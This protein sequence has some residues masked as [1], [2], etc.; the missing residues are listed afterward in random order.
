MKQLSTLL[1]LLVSQHILAQVAFQDSNLPIVV[2]DTKG[3]TIID[4]PKVD[5]HLGIVNNPGGLNSIDDPFNEY[6][7]KIG[8]EIRGSSSQFLFDKKSFGLET[9]DSTG[10][11]LNVGLFGFPPENDWVLHGPYS[12]KSLIRNLLAMHLARQLGHYTPRTQLC[13]L[14][15]NGDYRGVYLFMEKIKRD[16]GRV[17]I[18]KLKP[19]EITGDN[20]TGGYII[21]LDKYDGGN[22]GKGWSSPFPPNNA[23][24]GKEVFFQFDYPKVDQIVPQ[25]EE[26]IKS[27]VSD[28]EWALKG[29]GFRDPERGY[30]SFID[31]SSF[32]DF[33][34]V[35]E[36]TRNVDGYRLSTFLSKDKDSKDGRLKMGPVWD[37]NLAFGNAN[38]CEGSNTEGWAYNFN[39]ICP[40]DT[41]LIPFWWDRLMEDVSFVSQLN[42][43]WSELRQTYYMTSSIDNFID[44]IALVLEAPQQRNFQRWPVLDQ[45]IWPNN[46]IGNTYANEINYLKSWI[47]DRLLWIDEHLGDVITSIK[48]KE[49]LVISVFPNPFSKK[50]FIKSTS[51]FK[52]PDTFN[53]T[54][55][56]GR[57]VFRQNLPLYASRYQLSGDKLK[58]LRAGVYFY[59]L[60]SEGKTIQRGRLIKQ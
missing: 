50:L 58:Q 54:S 15:I 29:T 13:E 57:V 22:S 30:P 10:A 20:L 45:W 43:R 18:S 24:P 59:S 55:L 37:F 25:Q 47:G 26:Y 52:S 5:A 36:V 31:V 21:K 4:E 8:I 6:N 32:I 33:L 12:D 44:S 49:D 39:Q 53:I 60:E 51:S 46:F 9:R 27:Y 19:D 2:I 1:L 7:G 35:M 34:I 16:K 38:Y 28:F 11:N 48:T 23:L 42:A 41:W 40:D 17:N 3:N 14:V 56:D